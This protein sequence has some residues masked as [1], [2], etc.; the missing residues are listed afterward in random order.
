MGRQGE[1]PRREPGAKRIARERERQWEAVRTAGTSA[2][3]GG[4]RDMRLITKNSRNQ[5]NKGA[6]LLD[7]ALI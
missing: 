1:A 4:G 3:W 7:S 2:R 6:S 5:K